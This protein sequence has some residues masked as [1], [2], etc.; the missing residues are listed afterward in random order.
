MLHEENDNPAPIVASKGPKFNLS[1]N[2]K[3][4]EEKTKNIYAALSNIGESGIFHL[5]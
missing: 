4:E 3:A 5:T 1:R 2:K